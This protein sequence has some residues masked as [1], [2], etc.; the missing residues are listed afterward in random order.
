MLTGTASSKDSNALVSHDP[1]IDIQKLL[2]I[3]SQLDFKSVSKANHE[4]VLDILIRIFP[5][6]PPE[7]LAE[8]ETFVTTLLESNAA[9]VKTLIE[10]H[11]QEKSNSHFFLKLSFTIASTIAGAYFGAPITAACGKTAVTQIYTILFGAPDTKSFTY[12]V[13]FVPCQ[14]FVA[15]VSKQYGGYAIGILAAPSAYNL[16]SLIEY[17][18]AKVALLGSLTNP[19]RLPNPS[20]TYSLQSMDSIIA[21]FEELSV[22]QKQ[23]SPDPVSVIVG[24]TALIMYPNY[25]RAVADK[26][27]DSGNFKP[28]L[29]NIN[30]GAQTINPQLK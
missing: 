18:S 23:E 13:L 10:Q 29:A 8:I 25:Q 27:V 3:A 26:S 1:I 12:G 14:K 2:T 24:D 4:N 17:L 22:D 20:P 7:K 16:A 15:Y 6:H 5:D 9:K 28:L 30:S 11:P 19:K 21:E